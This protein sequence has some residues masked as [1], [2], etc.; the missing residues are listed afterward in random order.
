MPERLFR[1]QGRVQ[2][3]GFRWWTRSVARRLGITGTVRNL[4]DGSVEVRA[5]GT[6]PAL[7]QLRKELEAGPAGA[8]VSLIE[9]EQ[10][11]DVPASSFEIAR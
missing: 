6:A 1:V 11:T 5:N 9:E 10:A 4:P 3:V 2:G 8:E 7:A